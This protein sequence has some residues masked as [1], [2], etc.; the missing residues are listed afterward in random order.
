MIPPSA[1]RLSPVEAPAVVAPE[2]READLDRL[3]VR[4]AEARGQVSQELRALVPAGVLDREA[5][6]VAAIPVRDLRAA[7][8]V[9]LAHEL[10]V[11]PEAVRLLEHRHV[12]RAPRPEERLPAGVRRRAVRIEARPG[13]VR[14]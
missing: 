9:H 13:D 8:G 14:R 2:E 7:L 4:L 3:L 10:L 5:A 6:R 1:Q 11:E 12:A